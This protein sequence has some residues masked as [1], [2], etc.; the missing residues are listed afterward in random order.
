MAVKIAI[1]YKK[2]TEEIMNILDVPNGLA[3]DCV[4]IGCSSNLVAKANIKEKTYQV[5]AHFAHESIND[6]KDGL[7]TI[8]YKLTKNIIK[9]RGLI[10]LPKIEELMEH[11]AVDSLGA[12]INEESIAVFGGKEYVIN[13]FSESDKG[14][15]QKYPDL[16]I[17]VDN[18]GTKETIQVEIL[19][20]KTVDKR[21][22]HPYIENS[23]QKGYYH[24]IRID[25]LNIMD[26]INREAVEDSQFVFDKNYLTKI[27]TEHLNRYSWL[28]IKEGNIFK[29][30][31]KSNFEKLQKKIKERNEKILLMKNKL[32]NEYQGKKV[33]IPCPKKIT[34]S[35]TANNNITITKTVIANPKPRYEMEI[36]DIEFDKNIMKVCFI[37]NSRINFYI[38]NNK[39]WLNKTSEVNVMLL[40]VEEFLNINSNELFTT[41]EPEWCFN[42]KEN[43]LQK[44]LDKEI[45]I[46]N[47]G[48]R[49]KE[50]EEKRKQRQLEKERIENA[51]LEKEAIELENQKKIDEERALAQAKFREGMKE[52]IEDISWSFSMN[53][54][55]IIRRI[56]ELKINNED[57]LKLMYLEML[58]EHENNLNVLSNT[59]INLIEKYLK[60]EGFFI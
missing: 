41:I 19:L 24:H 12:T 25:M 29:D 3:C 27:L 17:E 4:C 53:K 10:Y 60:E 7:K 34:L 2:N 1:A 32:I 52:V 50:D 11:S 43:N 6:C 31:H 38:Q 39:K 42:V 45:R 56:E 49:K 44:E 15:N 37:N 26:I 9:E 5:P 8:L 28:I 59:D 22:R 13:N 30:Q 46:I 35:K 16:L 51:K 36:K 47:E 23:I 55:K 14:A 54:S 33:F 21:K 20:N 58:K 18:N 40:R 57:K 48:I